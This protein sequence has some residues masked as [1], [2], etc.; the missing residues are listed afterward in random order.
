MDFQIPPPSTNVSPKLLLKIDIAGGWSL[1]PIR[2][3]VG[4]PLALCERLEPL[5]L[6]G[7]VVDEHVALATFRGDESESLGLVEPLDCSV[8]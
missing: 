5:T 3:I 6:D 8:K 2:D 1:R 4:N 7:A